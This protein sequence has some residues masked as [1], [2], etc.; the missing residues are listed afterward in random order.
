MASEH[1]D[2]V[3]VGSGSAGAVLAERLTRGAQ[4]EFPRVLLLEAGFDWTERAFDAS[5]LEGGIPSDPARARRTRIRANAT[6]DHDADHE[7]WEYFDQFGQHH[8]YARHVGGSSAHN[9]MQSMTGTRADHAL[10]PDGWQY[11]DLAPFY[12]EVIERMNVRPQP[13]LTFDHGALAFERA[14]IA[15]GIPSVEELGV[16]FNDAYARSGQDGAIFSSAVGPT[17]ANIRGL[18]GNN[19]GGMVDKYG[20]RQSVLE[21]YV[22]D[23]RGRPNLSLRPNAWVTHV[24]VRSHG[25]SHRAQSVTFVDQRTGEVEG[26]SADLVIL[27]C[28]VVG[29]PALLMRSNIGPHA[30]PRSSNRHVP[31]RHVGRQY[32]NQPILLIGVEY[33]RE[34]HPQFGYNLPI[35]VNLDY[36]D[37]ERAVVMG[38]NN[39]AH[40]SIGA[41]RDDWGAEFKDLARNWR[42]T[43]YGFVFLTHP[44]STGELRLDETKDNTIAI[45]FVPDPR[46]V[47]E[48]GRAADRMREI[49][50]SID[51]LSLDGELA[52]LRVRRTFLMPGYAIASHGIATCRMGS[53]AQDSVVDSRTLL[54]HGFENLMVVDGGVFPA[55][56]QSPHVPISAVGLRAASTIVLPLLGLGQAS[57]QA[58]AD[59]DDRRG[60][61]DA[62][63][64]GRRGR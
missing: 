46:D 27:C 35:T 52:G 33:E 4:P 50:E 57:D 43:Q 25:H 54:V 63:R 40:P 1:W 15:S 5:G 18:V 21:T 20:G 45:D 55:Q 24:E 30:N 41:G 49:F 12:R 62:K 29:T 10:W 32:R 61:G 17:T 28:G 2:V 36:D 23:A 60:R 39:N 16:D 37:L 42:R 31:L 38:V 14:A 9:G 22:E 58:G 13:R 44:R 56:V 47:I 3:I 8:D 11:D 26:A 34:I 64:H 59:P 53:S 19:N 51:G 48:L 6:Q 7:H